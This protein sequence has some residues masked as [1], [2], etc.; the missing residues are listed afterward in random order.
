MTDTFRLWLATR[1]YSW[2][3]GWLWFLVA[4]PLLRYAF[5]RGR[6]FAC[7]GPALLDFDCGDEP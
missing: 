3:P 7:R 6:W 4:S 2:M 1:S 5:G